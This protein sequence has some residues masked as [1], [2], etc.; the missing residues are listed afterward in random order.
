MDPLND[1]TV[2]MRYIALVKKG[3]IDDLECSS[4]DSKED[5]DP[6]MTRKVKIFEDYFLPGTVLLS[7]R[8]NYK[9]RI[10]YPME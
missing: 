8:A 5:V 2:R 1:E 6:C 9:L 7:D 3:L 4:Y 10:E